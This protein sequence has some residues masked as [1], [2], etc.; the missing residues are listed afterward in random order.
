MKRLIRTTT[1]F[2]G[3]TLVFYLLMVYLLN[4]ISYENRR[5]IC[6]AIPYMPKKG[7]QE[8]SM[9]SDF[10][11]RTNHDIIVL[12]S[13][14]AYRGY[15]PDIFD[16]LGLDLF[17]M[18]SSSQHPM[19]SW[20]L[21]NRF[22]KPGNV[23][24]VILDV[25][26]RT[27]ELEGMDCTTRLIQH[28]PSDAAAFDLFTAEPDLRSFNSFT[29]R[30]MI[31]NLPSEYEAPGYVRDGYC[32]LTDTLD[33]LK[34][35][36]RS[37]FI[38]N[39]TMFDHLEKSLRWLEMNKIPCVVVSHPQPLV[40]TWINYHHE[41]RRRLDPMLDQYQVKYYDMTGEAWLRAE[42]HF[43]DE[44]HLNQA[45]VTIFNQRL[46]GLLRDDGYLQEHGK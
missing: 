28:V 39:T 22:I 18:G 19:A 20:V 29:T 38:P 13:S 2:I 21:L 11:K 4:E 25:Y 16:S 6:V 31:R 45:G 37:N 27:F 3:F 43:A 8:M 1:I 46:V 26:D 12:G 14:H 42:E 36:D 7:G 33:T 15:D 40:P 34:A 32:S 35:E 41:F 30:L 5:A 10:Q 23:K 17:N 9:F 44:N 24:L